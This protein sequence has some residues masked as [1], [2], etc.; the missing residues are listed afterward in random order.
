MSGNHSAENVSFYSSRILQAPAWHFYTI[1]KSVCFSC[2]CTSKGNDPGD[3]P[4]PGSSCLL[5]I[6]P[7]VLYL[8]CHTGASPGKVVIGTG[9]NCTKDH[10]G[11][12]TRWMIMFH[13]TTSMGIAMGQREGFSLQDGTNGKA[14]DPTY[15]HFYTCTNRYTDLIMLGTS[16]FP[17][18]E[19]CI[20]LF[21][22]SAAFWC[23]IDRTTTGIT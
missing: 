6:A 15:H 20:H 23:L 10:F 5:G 14:Q 16:G 9:W 18:G 11:D 8:P 7:G 2:A 13:L 1:W 3:V 4:G 17:S 19:E 12:F 22:N 21:M